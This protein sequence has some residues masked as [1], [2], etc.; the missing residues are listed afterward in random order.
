[1]PR[2]PLFL[3]ELLGVRLGSI[4]VSYIGFVCFLGFVGQSLCSWVQAHTT[5]WLNVV[6][7]EDVRMLSHFGDPEYGSSFCF[8][9][10]L[11]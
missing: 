7:L 2:V 4:A 9:L 11:L 1:M 6:N 3:S 10:L 8:F 5:V